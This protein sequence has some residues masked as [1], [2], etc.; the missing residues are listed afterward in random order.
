[1]G[2]LEVEDQVKGLEAAAETVGYLDLNRVAVIGWSYGQPL[3][4]T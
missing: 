1:M 3:P 4:L 2:K